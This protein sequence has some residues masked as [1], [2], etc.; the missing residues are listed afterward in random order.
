M[1]TMAELLHCIDDPDDDSTLAYQLVDEITASGDKALIPLLAAELDSVLNTGHFYGR[2]VIADILAGL[3]G[4]D[5]LPLLI[6]ASARNLGDDQDGLQSTI[7]ELM[8][9]NKQ[10]VR[11]VLD[12]LRAGGPPE[13]QHRV[14]WA[15]ELLDSGLI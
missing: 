8:S 11:I 10:Q 5:V 6:A 13:I 3:G 1:A 15:Y 4:I 7:L 9:T 14:T 2:D 12:E